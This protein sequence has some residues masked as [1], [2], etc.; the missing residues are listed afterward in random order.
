VHSCEVFEQISGED[1]GLVGDHE[2]AAVDDK[3]CSQH[4]A[5]AD[6]VAYP[7]QYPYLEPRIGK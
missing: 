7:T 3:A 4:D 1:H 2:P 5:D 6:L